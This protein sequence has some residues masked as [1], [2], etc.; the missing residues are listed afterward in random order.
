MSNFSKQ[1]FFDTLMEMKQTKKVTNRIFLDYASITP[2]APEVLEAMRPWSEGEG[3]NFANP[4]ALY[5]EAIVAKDTVSMARRQIAEILSAQ[6]PDGK[7]IIFTSGGTESNNLALLGVFNAYYSTT[8]NPTVQNIQKDT[9]VQFVPH[10]IVTAIEHPAILEVCEEIKRRGG[11]VTVLPV[12]EDGVVSAASVR[13]ALREN[14]VL[15]SV[16]Y[17]NN[18][19]GTVQ[20]IHEIGRVIKEFR[21]QKKI[22]DS[23]APGPTYPYFHTD[24][25]QAG[26]YLPLNILKLGVDLMTLD[27]IKLYGPRGIG[28]L[29]VRDGV[30]ISPLLHGGGQQRGLRS[31]T[32]NVAGIV[33]LAAALEVAETLREKE[34]AQLTDLRDY[35]I[36]KI[37]EIFPH[38]SLN[39]SGTERLPNNINICFPGID[40]EFTVISLDIAGIAASYSSS[41]RTLSEN[42]SSYVIEALGKKECAESSLR[43]TMGR[44]T[45]REDVDMLVEV[46]REVIKVK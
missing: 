1:V 18:E 5:T 16:M 36:K 28:L 17:A 42:S 29:Y 22:Q 34:S 24:A 41:C 20:P 37:L 33:G 23:S 2:I 26:L 14:T 43:F 31:G 6:A 30:Q 8:S 27:G 9:P 32:E 39:G 40:A 13:D 12:S 11:E 7:E 44:E 35:G 45:T 4:S 15:V 25:C 10:Y 46:L 3:S 19:I 38:A 21:T